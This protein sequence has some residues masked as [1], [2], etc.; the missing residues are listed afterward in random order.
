MAYAKPTDKEIRKQADSANQLA[1]EKANYQSLT[2]DEV[3]LD[4]A[5]A[6]DW[7]DPGN[8]YVYGFLNNSQ[9]G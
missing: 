6:F 9:N 8:A 2:F 1:Q 5:E 7:V 3:E 4:Y